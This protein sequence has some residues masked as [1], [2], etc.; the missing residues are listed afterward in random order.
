ML[1]LLLLV[2][3]A[4]AAVPLQTAEE[5]KDI[6]DPRR[7]SESAAYW[8]DQ[9]DLD[10]ARQMFELALSREEWV[11]E[12]YIDIKGPLKEALLLEELGKVE[13]SANKYRAAFADDTPS[14]MRC[15]PRPSPRC[16]RGRS[17][18]SAARR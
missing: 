17:G 16:A 6:D 3:T 15:S 8:R 14:A 13:D 1:V 12:H 9:G 7:L 18:R 4:L 10:K 5:A 11:S 2:L